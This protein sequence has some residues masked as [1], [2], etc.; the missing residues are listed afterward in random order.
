M[1]AAMEMSVELR[2]I[3]LVTFAAELVGEFLLIALSL[4]VFRAVWR[5]SVLHVNLKVGR[6]QRKSDCG[7]PMLTRLHWNRF[8]KLKI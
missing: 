5:C 2:L 6:R 4:F 8:S 7:E 1:V 3:C